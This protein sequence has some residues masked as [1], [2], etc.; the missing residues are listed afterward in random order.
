M[1]RRISPSMKAALDGVMEGVVKILNA[2]L[3]LALLCADG[4][5]VCGAD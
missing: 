5:G 1:E 2:R 3:S 4:R